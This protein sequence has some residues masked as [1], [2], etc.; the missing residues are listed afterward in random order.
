MHTGNEKQ[1][2]DPRN[3]GNGSHHTGNHFSEEFQPNLATASPPD[4]RRGSAPPERLS[5]FKWGYAP[6]HSPK[7][8]K[9]GFL[10]VDPVN[11]RWSH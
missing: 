4:V 10:F 8:S 9:I 2:N 5:L 1:Q 7:A 3:T 11:R 6:E